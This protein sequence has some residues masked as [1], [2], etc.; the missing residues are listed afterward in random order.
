MQKLNK[1]L[2]DKISI[3]MSSSYVFAQFFP[4][5]IYLGNICISILILMLAF[6]LYTSKTSI[7]INLADILIVSILAYILLQGLYLN[8]F[9]SVRYKYLTLF[10]TLFFF[11]LTY[12]LYT[13]HLTFS[14][15]VVAITITVFNFIFLLKI[16]IT[17][18][19]PINLIE[20]YFDNIS[21]YCIFLALSSVIIIH[22]LKS[23]NFKFAKYIS[24]GLTILTLII[25]VILKSRSAFILLS[26]YVILE[27]FKSTSS[28]TTKYLIPSIV[29]ILFCV[30]SAFF[31]KN[32][33]TQGRLFIWK[34]SALMINDNFF[35]GIGYDKFALTYPI[36][37]ASQYEANNMT[38]KEIYLADNTAFAFNEYIHITAELGIVGLIMSLL[39]TVFYFYNGGNYKTIYL[40]VFIVLLFSYIIHSSIIT[41]TIVLMLSINKVPYVYKMNKTWSHIF[42]VL[43]ILTAIYSFIVSTNKQKSLMSL[44]IAINQP[45]DR[46]NLFYNRHTCYLSD[47]KSFIFYLA[48]LNYNHKEID[49]ALSMLEQLDNLITRDEIEVLKGKIYMKKGMFDFAEKHLRLSVAICPNRFINRYEL[50][51]FYIDQ[52]LEEQALQVAKEILILKEKV[53]SPHTITIKKQIENYLNK[54]SK[55][56]FSIK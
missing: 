1:N 15:H 7:E 3:T 16:I 52:G 47:N 10:V 30:I 41:Y 23:S 40:S 37:Q 39:I 46:I 27:Y 4:E 2:V 28:R 25:I 48:E 9:N 55:T 34:T 56:F 11:K 50:F 21:L 5:F 18:D 13:K 29:V 45:L 42:L 31:V 19:S 6:N 8:Q 36:Y 44:G 20:R 24:Y 35:T 54:K 51:N 22:T 26:S 14:K 43:I 12:T 32:D 53:Q 17:K 33:S 38:Q 49:S